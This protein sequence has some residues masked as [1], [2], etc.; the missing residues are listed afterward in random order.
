MSHE[1]DKEC[2][3]YASQIVKPMMAYFQQ[4]NQKIDQCYAEIESKNHQIRQLEERETMLEKEVTQLKV[5]IA[6]A[7]SKDKIIKLLEEKNDSNA[8]NIKY[9]KQEN[10]NLIKSMEKQAGVSCAKQ[11]NEIIEQINQIRS[12]TQKTIKCG[13]ELISKDVANNK[14]V[15]LFESEAKNLTN[16]IERITKIA[17]IIEKLLSP[18]AVKCET[19]LKSRKEI[20]TAIERKIEKMETDHKVSLDIISKEN[21]RKNKKGCIARDFTGVYNVTT[22]NGFTFEVLCNHDILG[23]GWTVIQQR[24][25]GGV[26][27]NR[28]WTTYRNGFGDFWDGDFF[29]GLDK[30]HR[31]TSEKPHELYIHMQSINGSTYFARYDQ[32]AISGEDDLYRLIKLDKFSGNNIVDNFAY[33][34]YQRFSTYDRDNDNLVIINCAEYLKCGWWHNNCYKT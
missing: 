3:E 11:I 27:F 15:F 12:D 8:D 4:A 13:T 16:S 18:K 29:L 9:L 20:N 23:P 31:L 21:D 32:F 7:T 14:K 5:E 26:D 28:N 24:L 25:R 1:K 33:N 2:G 34:K 10:Q 19:E 17:E 30:I 6:S 22:A